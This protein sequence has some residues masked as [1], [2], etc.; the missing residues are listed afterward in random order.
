M[1]FLYV[2]GLGGFNLRSI[3]MMKFVM[4]D[5][6]CIADGR[7]ERKGGSSEEYPFLLINLTLFLPRISINMIST[8]S[9]NISVECSYI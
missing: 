9:A 4:S 7:N 6:I 1:Q 3:E 2:D 5:F 8:Y